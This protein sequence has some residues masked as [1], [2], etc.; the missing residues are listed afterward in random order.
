MKP[1]ALRQ[2]PLPPLSPF[3]QAAC[4]G[5]GDGGG[6]LQTTQFLQM[7]LLLYSVLFKGYMQ[8]FLY[9]FMIR[10]S[11]VLGDKLLLIIIMAEYYCLIGIV[12]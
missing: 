12:Q 10:L 3:L 8:Y 4:Q 11:I 1:G 6:G 5:K 7:Y 2:A 9:R